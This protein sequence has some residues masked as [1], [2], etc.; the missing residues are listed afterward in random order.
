MGSH[1]WSAV[2]ISKSSLVSLPRSRGRKSSNS[3]RD[4][5]NCLGFLLCP[6]RVSK[7]FRFVKI[8][9]FFNLL[10]LKSILFIPS[11][12]YLV[13]ISWLIPLKEKMSPILPITHTGM[14]CCWRR[15]RTVNLDGGRLKSLREGVRIK[16]G[17][18]PIKGRAITLSTSQSPLS[19]CL[20]ISQIR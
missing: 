12:L 19:N 14:L 15:S 11:L 7:S 18:S 9:P 5:E 10:K 8:N 2:I 20:A 1:P 17:L 4:S 3:L 16:F 6:K 13:R